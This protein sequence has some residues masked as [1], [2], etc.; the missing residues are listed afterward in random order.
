MIPVNKA[1]VTPAVHSLE[2]PDLANKNLRDAF[3]AHAKAL[4]V[5]TV[6]CNSF[7]PYHRS[8]ERAL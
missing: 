3:D 2:A 5:L 6:Q 1:G 8:L 4:L 7:D